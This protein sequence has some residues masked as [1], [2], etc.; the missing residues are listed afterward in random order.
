MK[1]LKRLEKKEFEEILSERGCAFI[2]NGIVYNYMD[3]YH[4]EDSFEIY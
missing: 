4:V 2:K 3:L 1:E